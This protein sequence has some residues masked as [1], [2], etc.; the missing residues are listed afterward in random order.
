MPSGLC[1]TFD[2][3]QAIQ[4]AHRQGVQHYSIDNAEEHG[5]RADA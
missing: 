5:I 4:G 1:N 3:N 2:A